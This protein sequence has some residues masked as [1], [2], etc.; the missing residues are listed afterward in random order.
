MD[1]LNFISWIKA[2]NYR[3][4]LPTD[5]ESVLT[6]G[7][8][9]PSRDDGWLSLAVD[10]AP[11]Q[12]LY[13]TANV[14]QITSISTAVTVNAYNGII[15]VVSTAIAAGGTAPVFIVNNS[16]VTTSSRIVLSCQY[17]AAGNG[18]PNAFVTNISNGSFSIRI[19]NGGSFILNQA[20]KVHFMI[21]N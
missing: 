10:A 15:T 18:I 7:A 17:P 20:V 9:D 8:K 6:I 3:T 16:N 19:A 14:T 12:A 1:I 5:T 2:G 11:L 13:N 4:T 21:I